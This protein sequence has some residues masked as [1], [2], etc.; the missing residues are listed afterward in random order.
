MRR[1]RSYF[2][3]SARNGIAIESRHLHS[4]SFRRR[5]RRKNGRDTAA[6]DSTMGSTAVVADRGGARSSFLPGRRAA[7]DHTWLGEGLHASWARRYKV[8]HEHHQ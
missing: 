3:I 7:E 1:A 5:L 8:Q 4:S 6:G 2:K